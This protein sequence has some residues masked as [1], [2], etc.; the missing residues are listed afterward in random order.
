MAEKRKKT[1]CIDFDG[2]L[3]DYSKGYQGL[4]VFGEMMK[5]ADAATRTLRK[6]GWTII[7]YT[8]RPAT[9]KLRK[10]L[11]DNKVEYDYINENPDQP[12]ESKGCKLVADIYLDDRSMR[13]YNWHDAVRQIAERPKTPERPDDRQVQEAFDK[14]YKEGEKWRE[15]YAADCNPFIA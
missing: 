10:W 11:E 14:A 3:A 4:D 13:F 8:T 9:D 2:V 1:I 15:K 7:I 5:G 6:N 12:E